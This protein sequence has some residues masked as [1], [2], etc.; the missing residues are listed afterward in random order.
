MEATLTIG[1]LAQRAGVNASAIRYYER[2]GLLPAPE[3]EYGQRRYDN[4]TVRRLQV[5]DVA[6]RAGFTL[7]DARILLADGDGAPPAHQPIRD[8]ARRKLPEVE[9]LIAQAEA[10]RD[11]LRTA[12]GCNCETLD[13]CGLFEEGAGP[14]ARPTPDRVEPTVARAYP[15]R[16]Q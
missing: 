1:Q 4:A 2:I 15:S 16:V 10:M 6:K 13:V 9:A 7:D 8:L 12:D 11:W 3:R 14:R 5:I